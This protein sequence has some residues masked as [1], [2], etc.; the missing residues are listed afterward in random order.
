M[1]NHVWNVQRFSRD[2][3]QRGLY[4]YRL[5]RTE[6]DSK[7]A[8]LDYLLALCFAGYVMETIRQQG[9]E[10]QCRMRE[11]GWPAWIHKIWAGTIRSGHRYARGRNRG[12]YEL[13]G[14]KM[15]AAAVRLTYGHSHGG[16]E[17][18]LGGLL[19][20]LEETGD[21]LPVLRDYLEENRYEECLL[22]LE[23]SFRG[24]TYATTTARS[25]DEPEEVQPDSV[26][27]TAYLDLDLDPDWS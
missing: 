26:P 15:L 24:L 18:Q 9:G 8:R 16:P 10:P 6:S 3:I 11:V 17:E 5:A 27:T 1:S 13:A 2:T 23:G 22:I 20:K 19:L 4:A 21:V 12:N 14:R 25:E 7:P